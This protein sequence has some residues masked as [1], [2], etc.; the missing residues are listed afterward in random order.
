MI[1]ATDMLKDMSR[2]K[3][4]LLETSGRLDRERESMQ[5][6]IDA[7]RRAAERVVHA[8]RNCAAVVGVAAASVLPPRRVSPDAVIAAVLSHYGVSLDEFRGSGRHPRVVHAREMC[9]LMFRRHTTLGY[10]EIAR[11]MGR[12]AHSTLVIAHKRALRRQAERRA[13]ILDLDRVITT[14]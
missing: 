12:T 14:R 10:A 1:R 9:V 5:A 7:G 2:K 4:D 6:A 11:E 8:P 3:A 13:E